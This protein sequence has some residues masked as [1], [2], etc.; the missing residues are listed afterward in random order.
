MCFSQH[1]VRFPIFLPPFSCFPRLLLVLLAPR[2]KRRDIT[3]RVSKTYFLYMPFS[4]ARYK[5]FGLS[6]NPA[7]PPPMPPVACFAHK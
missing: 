3:K 1:L 5:D 2:R 4:P 7:L 6:G